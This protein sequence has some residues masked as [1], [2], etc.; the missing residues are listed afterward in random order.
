MSS[1]RG[2]K[3]TDYTSG[4][5]FTSNKGGVKVKSFY[6]VRRADFVHERISEGMCIEIKHRQQM[7][8]M[9]RVIEHER[10]LKEKKF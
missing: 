9:V 6:G 1:W 4:Y 2:K 3:A 7:K 10:G 5:T 8:D